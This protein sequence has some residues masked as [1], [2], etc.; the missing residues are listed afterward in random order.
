[1]LSMLG[2]LGSLWQV[3]TRRRRFEAEM[4]EEIRLHLDEITRELI[5]A[6][7]AP[8]EAARRAR[9]EFGSVLNIESDCRAARGVAPFDEAARQVR[10]ALRRLRQSPGFTVTALVTLGLC[11]GASLTVFAAV[12]AVLLRPLPFPEPDRLVRVFNSY[13]KAGVPDDGANLTNYFERRGRI[14]AFSGIALLRQ[15]AAVVGE[16]G[17][18]ERIAV[19]RVTP[20]FFA[21]L[22]VRPAF[23]RGFEEAECASGLGR[24]RRA[25]R[26]VLAPAA[27]GRRSPEGGARRHDPRRR[28]GQADRRHPAAVVPVPLVRGADLPAVRGGSGAARA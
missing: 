20:G 1:M 15:D 25:D 14:A 9:R 3:L 2:R 23:G 27:R 8:D 28:G 10:L 6:G 21:V 13:P 12:D 19:T 22:G 24:R 18:T 26:R 7:V 4:S 5:A 11:L 16:T 17:A